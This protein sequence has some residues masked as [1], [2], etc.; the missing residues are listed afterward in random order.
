[1]NQPEGKPAVQ[2]LHHALDEL[3]K[4]FDEQNDIVIIVHFQT[5]K[6]TIVKHNVNID[7]DHSIFLIQKLLDK[8]KTQAAQFLTIKANP[9]Y[10]GRN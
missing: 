8:I 9:N 4:N 1:M 3:K 10:F 5:Q 7:E 6:G 2:P